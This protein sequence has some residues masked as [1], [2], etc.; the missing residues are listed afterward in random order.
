MRKPLA[1]TN[2][3]AGSV[4]PG[5]DSLPRLPL[6]IR[7]VPEGSR[8]NGRAYRVL[9]AVLAAGFSAENLTYGMGGGLLQQLDR[10]TQS[11]AYKVSWVER[12]GRT[13]RCAST[14]SPTR[15]SAARP[16]CSI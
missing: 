5:R 8:V 4:T 7:A 11:F 15:P 2:R 12:S 14:P 16:A 3:P 13:S 6:R 9:D 1:G 10:D